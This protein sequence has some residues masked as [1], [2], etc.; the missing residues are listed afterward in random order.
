MR[1]LIVHE[2]LSLDGVLQAPGGADEDRDGGFTYGGWAMAIVG[3][4]LFT[5]LFGWFAMLVGGTIG[6][7]VEFVWASFWRGQDRKQLSGEN[8]EPSSAGTTQSGEAPG[9][10]P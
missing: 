4:L 8:E 5:V 7:F 1:K 6:G 2:F 10:R 3:A 9:P